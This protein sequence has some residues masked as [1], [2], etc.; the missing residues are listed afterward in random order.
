MKVK[1]KIINMSEKKIQFTGYL[2]L[3]GAELVDCDIST[4]DKCIEVLHKNSVLEWRRK[5]DDPLMLATYSLTFKGDGTDDLIIKNGPSFDWVRVVLNGEN[6][7][8]KYQYKA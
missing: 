4:I 3:N 6:I 1:L 7:I 5:K 2:A 8:G